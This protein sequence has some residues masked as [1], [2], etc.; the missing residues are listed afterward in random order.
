[1]KTLW[2]KV[3]TRQRKLSRD[4]NKHYIHADR[5]L[6]ENDPMSARRSD[7]IGA[8]EDKSTI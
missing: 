3:K 5:A 4:G 2:M 1:M 8:S 6:L 7:N